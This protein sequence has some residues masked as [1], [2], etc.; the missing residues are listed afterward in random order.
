MA[1]ARKNPAAAP[2]PGREYKLRLPD[3]VAERIAKKAE[4]EG[5]P[6][7]RVIINELALVPYLE[8]FRNLADQIRNMEIILAR[9]GARIEWHDLQDDLLAAVDAVLSTSANAPAA[10]DNLRAVRAVMLQT[11]KK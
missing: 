11:K 1:S 5:R 2:R 7:N 10:L 3:D 6:Q 8:Q 4:A 9:H